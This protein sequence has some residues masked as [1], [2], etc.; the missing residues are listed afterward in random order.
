MKKFPFGLINLSKVS[1]FFVLLLM[2]VLSI[3]SPVFAQE[4]NSEVAPKCGKDVKSC[5]DYKERKLCSNCSYC[6]WNFDQVKCENK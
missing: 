5:S 4:S 6:Q 3:A 1:L 2:I